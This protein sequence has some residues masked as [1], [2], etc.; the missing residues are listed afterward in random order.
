MQEEMTGGLQCIPTERRRFPGAMIGRI[1]SIIVRYKSNPAL[2]R[3][4][5][6]PCP[7]LATAKVPGINFTKELT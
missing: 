7:L 6:R 2:T 3:A 1:A 4:K 5:N